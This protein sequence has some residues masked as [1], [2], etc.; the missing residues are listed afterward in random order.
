MDTDTDTTPVKEEICDSEGNCYCLRMAV[1]GKTDSASGETDVSAFVDWL[2]N[3]SSCY[4]T[5]F[6][7]KVE[8]TESCVMT[9]AEAFKRRV[10]GEA[11]SPRPRW[12]RSKPG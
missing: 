6:E 1:I 2:N 9:N 3:D 4:V 7:N 10:G 8:L 11:V 5:L 12:L